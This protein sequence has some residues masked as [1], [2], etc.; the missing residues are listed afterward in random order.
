MHERGEPEMAKLLDSGAERV[1]RRE[2]A[3]VE[4]RDCGHRPA[5]ECAGEYA[6]R[7][8]CVL[9]VWRRTDH[10]AGWAGQ[11]R[12]VLP[13]WGRAGLRGPTRSEERRVGKECRSAWRP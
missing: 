4:R 13:G 7:V 9:P 3:G 11:V 2:I 8:V 12:Y 10:H 5:G 6:G 1:F